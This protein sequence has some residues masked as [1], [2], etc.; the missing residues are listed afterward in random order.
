MN[1]ILITYVDM[2]YQSIW[3]NEFCKKIKWQFKEQNIFFRLVKQGSLLSYISQHILTITMILFLA[4][5]RQSLISIGYVLILIPY[6]KES[7]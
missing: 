5:C 2:K 3:S 1:E 6:L 4:V 7:A